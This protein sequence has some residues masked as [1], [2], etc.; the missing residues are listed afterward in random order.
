MKSNRR[1]NAILFDKDG[2][3]FGF[4][5]SWS[6][7][8]TT[9]LLHFSCG[10]KERAISSGIHIGYDLVQ[11]VFAPSCSI[12]AGTPEVI[13]ELMVNEFP[14]WDRNEIITFLETSS[15]VVPMAEAV[16]LRPYFSKLQSQNFTLGVVTNDSESIA[17]IQLQ[18]SGIL[19]YMAYIAGYDSGFTAKPD[20]A[21]LLAFCE[22]FSIS[23]HHVAMV[24]DS[25]SD[26][27]AAR[28]AEMLAIGVLTGI[29][30]R[31]ELEPYADFIFNDIGELPNWLYSAYMYPV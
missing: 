5:K 6:N 28:N 18:R 10:N 23:R 26:L 20:P 8:L 31:Q 7:W 3:L 25:K 16:P 21:M 1:I 14:E 15:A 4:A 11:G 12:I 29:A 24:G 9:V 17:R 22:K 19:E 30:N 2:T 27:L 13:I